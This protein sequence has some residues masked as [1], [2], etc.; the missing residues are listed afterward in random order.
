METEREGVR[1]GEREGRR[2]G[3]GAVSTC[4]FFS[5][6]ANFFRMACVGMSGLESGAMGLTELRSALWMAH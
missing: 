4:F 2:R 6:A 5:S 3:G 1:E